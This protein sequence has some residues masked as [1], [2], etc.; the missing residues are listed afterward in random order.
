MMSDLGGTPMRIS[1]N[2]FRI[3]IIAVFLSIGCD[4]PV[5]PP[6]NPG[7]I[8]VVVM[9]SGEDVITQGLRVNV[10]NGP[11]RE[12]GSALLDLTIHGMAPGVHAVRV[13]GMAVNCQI[14]SANPR[15]VT[16]V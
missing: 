1:R 16:V 14:A 10:L 15:S 9:P 6:N 7:A 5:R 13:E 11:I 12:F 8:H 2:S 4:D 3:T